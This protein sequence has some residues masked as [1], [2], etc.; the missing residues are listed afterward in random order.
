MTHLNRWRR[1]SYAETQARADE[2]RE[3]ALIDLSEE[4]SL[5]FE[6][7]DDTQAWRERAVHEILL[8]DSD[9]VDSD[10]CI[11]DPDTPRARAPLRIQSAGRRPCAPAPAIRSFVRRVSCSTSIS[12]APKATPHHLSSSETLPS[13]KRVTCRMSMTA[14]LKTSRS[15]ERCGQASRTTRLG[16]GESTMSAPRGE[17]GGF[18]GLVGAADGEKM[19]SRD[20][21]TRILSWG[22]TLDTSPGGCATRRTPG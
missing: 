8:R 13:F 19:L 15:G 3:P 17:R 2:R 22:S 10:C 4:W 12:Q 20:I 9:H 18:D 6:L 1:L 11:S 7:L 21:S 14:H 16:L 5:T